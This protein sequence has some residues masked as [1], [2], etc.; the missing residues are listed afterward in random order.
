MR[1]FSLSLLDNFRIRSTAYTV[2]NPS[3]L[4]SNAITAHSHLARFH[5]VLSGNAWIEATDTGNRAHLHPGD[6]V[7]IPNGKAHNLSARPG[8]KPTLTDELPENDTFIEL[9]RSFESVSDTQLLCGY[10]RVSD[11]IPPVLQ[12]K[13]P[14]LV[15][16]R[17]TSNEDRER[18]Q[19]VFHLVRSELSDS[20]GLRLAV[21]NRLSEILCMYAIHSWLNKALT[22]DVHLASLFDANLQQVLWE[23]HTEPTKAWTVEKLSEICGQSRTA[24]ATRFKAIMGVGPIN[25]VTGCRIRYAM[26]LLQDSDLSLDQIAEKSGYSDT[27]AFN[28]AFKRETSSAPGAFRRA[29]RE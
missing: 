10:Y 20:S 1:D 28:R 29:S 18:I 11:N 21:L 24:F 27:N 15:I 6:Y 17:G 9:Q 3:G 19:A 23:I 26:R 8:M 14:D 7:L 12:A 25:Y 5:L 4:W 16:Q 13:L 2:K 22:G